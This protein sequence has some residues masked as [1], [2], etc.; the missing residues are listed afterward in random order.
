MPIC[1]LTREGR[2]EVD[3]NGSGGRKGQRGAGGGETIIRIYCTKNT[4]F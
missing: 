2:K 3:V 1:S 4:Y